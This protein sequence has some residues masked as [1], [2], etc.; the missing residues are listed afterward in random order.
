MTGLNIKYY[1]TI[2]T[3]ALR[4]LVDA[5]GG[6]TFNVP[7]NM[8]YDDSSQDLYIHLKAGE[9]LLNGEQSRMGSKI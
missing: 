2:D 7:I 8:D 4:H 5:I 6:V 3:A 9:H 1:V